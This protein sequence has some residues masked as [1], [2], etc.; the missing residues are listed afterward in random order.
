MRNTSARRRYGGVVVI[1]VFTSPQDCGGTC[2]YCPRE[3]GVPRG[4]ISHNA[5][6]RA[7]ALGFSPSMQIRSMLDSRGSGLYEGTPV[8]LIVLGG[9]FSALSR[10]YRSYF[11]GACLDELAGCGPHCVAEHRARGY[12]CSI[13][14]VE[15]RP[16]YIDDDECVFLRSLGV[17][18]VELGVQ[19]LDDDVLAECQRGHDASR[20][21]RATLLLKE[22]GFKVGYHVMVGLPG[23][24]LEK[25]TVMI[26]ERLW[27]IPHSPDFLKVYPCVLLRDARLQPSL[28]A[29]LTQGR[30][31]PPT[32]GYVEQILR[33]LVDAC[34]ATVRICRVQRYFP[35]MAVSGGAY[36]GLNEATVGRC[37][38]IRCNEVGRH[39]DRQTDVEVC[40]YDTHVDATG[41]EVCILANCDDHT[42]LGVVRL[43]LQYHKNTVL[44]RELH[45]YG[46]AVS[47]GLMGTVQGRGLGTAL[48]RQAEDFG[49]KRGLTEAKAN[50]APGA[51]GFFFRHGYRM[52]DAGYLARDL[53]EPACP[54]PSRPL[55]IADGF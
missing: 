7:R 18:K 45:V 29:L 9:N 19:H 20:V 47:L 49:C 32:R 15:S 53:R 24:S 13:L 41:K 54:Y 23:S 14:T 48:L 4:Y 46:D 21:R 26:A 40:Q 43:R 30:W 51:R 22:H 44:I 6:I 36:R 55:K 16:D 2:I 3:P 38:C 1:P 33:V 17:S 37:R 31:R 34:P 39:R 52:S 28:H 11:V 42:V 8:E 35:M 10:R 27:E 50:V 12:P 25:D 5:L